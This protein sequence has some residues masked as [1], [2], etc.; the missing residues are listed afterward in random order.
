MFSENDVSGSLSRP[1]YG[2]RYCEP[3]EYPALRDVY[4]AGK[5]PNFSLILER[6]IFV[7]Q[8]KTHKSLEKGT[9]RTYSL[10]VLG[11]AK[12]SGFEIKSS[13]CTEGHLVLSLIHI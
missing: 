11:K 7:F 5:D 4:W 1:V 8:A 12:I 3:R 6:W 13:Q 9:F 2:F 10:K